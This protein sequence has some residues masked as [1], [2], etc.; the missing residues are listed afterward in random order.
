[1][2]VIQYARLFQE[3]GAEVPAGVFG[4]RGTPT[5]IDLRVLSESIEGGPDLTP[6]T[7]AEDAFIV[8]GFDDA[9]KTYGG[10]L[11]S[12]LRVDDGIA[13]LLLALFGQVVTTLPDMMGAPTANLHEYIPDDDHTNVAPSYGLDLGLEKKREYQYSGLLVNALTISKSGAG[14]VNLSWEIIA[15]DR[16][17]V[18]YDGAHVPAYATKT[19]LQAVQTA[20]LFGTAIDLDDMTITL[21]RNWDVTKNFKE[22][23]LPRAEY[24][25]WEAEVSVSF[26]FE[27]ALGG[28]LTSAIEKFE[29]SGAT[30]DESEGEM[31]I[32]FRGPVIAASEF[33]HFQIEFDRL[34]ITSVTPA[35]IVGTTR[36]VES[37]TLIAAKPS[38][39]DF[40]KVSL[41]NIVVTPA[42]YNN[43]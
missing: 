34:K 43:P 35:H 20:T 30:T 11:T 39:G 21:R 24:G 31:T 3:R 29:S 37:M 6:E 27:G 18:A 40:C 1:M 41:E 5:F 13:D 7:D 12:K 26:K 28:T 25:P 23:V 17:V 4:T 10:T 36:K 22:R 9:G 42:S 2:V 8:T 15:K 32:D 19:K 33:E 14:E 16:T 38:A